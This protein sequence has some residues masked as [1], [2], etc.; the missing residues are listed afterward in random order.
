MPKPG[1]GLES[2]CGTEKKMFARLRTHFGHPPISSPESTPGI[3]HI[4]INDYIDVLEM[5]VH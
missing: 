4:E 3:H 2:E 5:L 1:C